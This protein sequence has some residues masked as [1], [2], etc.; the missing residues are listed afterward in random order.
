VLD[1]GIPWQMMALQSN[2][3]SATTAMILGPTS[4]KGGASTGE[5]LTPARE[6]LL[7]PPGIPFGAFLGDVAHVISF[8]TGR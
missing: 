6:I 4:Q 7:V 8:F 2:S 5:K 1:A 3:S